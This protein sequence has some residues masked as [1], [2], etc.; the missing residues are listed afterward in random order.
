MRS[1]VFETAWG[2]CGVRISAEGLARVVIP[3]GYGRREI[4]RML[5]GDSGGAAP[6]EAKYLRDY[7]AGKRPFF[8]GPLD[9]KG[10]SGFERAVYRETT[11]IPR[12]K[13]VSYG[14]IARRIGRPGAARAVGAALA[15]NPVPIIVPCHRVVRADGSPGGFSSRGGT[16]TKKKLLLLERRP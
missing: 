11:K 3:D 9:L 16:A 5:G 7:F 1:C 15:K 6:A 14:K 2:W 10:R 4:E 8:N 13:T 12:G